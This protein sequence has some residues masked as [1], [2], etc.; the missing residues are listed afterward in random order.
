MTLEARQG[1]IQLCEGAY[2]VEKEGQKSLDKKEI[3]RYRITGEGTILE[4]KQGK[5]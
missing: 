2:G 5:G 3:L 4:T 1:R